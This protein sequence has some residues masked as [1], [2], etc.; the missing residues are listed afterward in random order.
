MYVPAG[1]VCI[2][3]CY[4]SS[5]WR[6]ERTID[7]GIRNLNELPDNPG[8]Y[9]KIRGGVDYHTNDVAYFGAQLTLQY[10]PLVAQDYLILSERRLSVNDMSLPKGGLFDIHGN[11]QTPHRSHREGKDADI[12][13]GG[14]A[15]EDDEDLMTAVDQLLPRITT[16]NGNTRSA[17]LCE[18]CSNNTLCRKHI[19]FESP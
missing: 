4:D 12:N 13:Q 16:S 9:T 5:S 10:L 19:D 6:Y 17:L 14:I 11:W 1:W 3:G 7:V 2:T 18:A 8:L 15:C